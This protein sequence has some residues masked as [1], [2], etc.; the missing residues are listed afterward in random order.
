MKR[1][2][3]YIFLM[4]VLL[5]SSCE[6]SK[7][8]DYKTI[9]DGDKLMLHGFISPQNGV[10]LILKKSVAPN[11][12]DADDKVP[13]ASVS[14]LKDG[15]VVAK[16]EKRGDYHYEVQRGFEFSYES[17]YSIKV[18]AD[19]FEDLYSSE[20]AIFEPI[21]IENL[22]IIRCENS[23][24]S[25]LLVEFTYNSGLDAGIYLKYL[26]YKNGEEESSTSGQEIFN[27]YSLETDIVNGKNIIEHQLKFAAFDSIKVELY[28]MS[29]DLKLFFE[30]TQN[31]ET[32][33]ED[34][35][36]EQPYPIFSNMTNGYGIFGSYSVSSKVVKRP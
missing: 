34:P 18:E 15:V 32:A 20:Q 13:N 6:L 3:L 25:N 2:I 4:S 7:E 5:F 35:F 30:S 12:V 16:L 8:I 31:Y 33:K 17:K 11:A 22:E 1:Q 24:C 26:R 36:F 23:S 28:T 14:L 9:Y 29:P 27:P 19:G 10:E 21:I